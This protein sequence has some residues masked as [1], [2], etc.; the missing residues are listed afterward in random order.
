MRHGTMRIGA[1]S[2]GVPSHAESTAARVLGMLGVWP[3]PR[4][5]SL[6]RREATHCPSQSI[7]FPV[8][9]PSSTATASS[10]AVR[11]RHWWF[12]GRTLSTCAVHPEQ[13]AFWSRR[14]PFHHKGGHPLRATDLSGRAPA[15]TTATCGAWTAQGE[16]SMHALGFAP[17]K[18]RPLS[19]P[20]SASSPTTPGRPLQTSA[21]TVRWFHENRTQG[22]VLHHLGCVDRLPP[23]R[24]ALHLPVLPRQPLQP[25]RP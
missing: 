21:A 7:A 10:P 12:R 23:R 5:R 14:G 22:V 25:V 2:T 1:R 4:R 11:G 18:A 15:P 8:F 19:P 16:S 13:P 9:A 6:L 3:G 17:V 20:T 24:S